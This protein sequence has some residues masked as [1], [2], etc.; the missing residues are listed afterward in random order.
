MRFT[1]L[2]PSDNLTG[3]ARVVAVYARELMALGHDVLVV[4]CKADSPGW[5]QRLRAPFAKKA[6]E[7][8]KGH[9]AVSGVPHKVMARYGAIAAGDVPDADVIIATWWETAV[10]MHAMPAAK[11]K[12]VHLIQGYEVWFGPAFL[13]KVHAAL[14]LPNIKIAIS[15]DLKETIDK[16]VPGLAISL[17]ANAVDLEQFQAPERVRNPLPQVGFIYA[18]A[19]IKGADVCAQACVL[20]RK[21]LPGLRVLAFGTDQPSAALPLPPQTQF[22][23]RP[24]QNALREHYAACDVWLFGSRLDSFG[25]PILEAMACRTPV[26]GVPVG[27]APDLIAG[28]G[29]VLVPGES[30]QAMSD[31]IIK[32]CTQPVQGWHAMSD[33]A[34]A[35]AHGYSW[36]DATRKLV[37]KITALN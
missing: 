4:T 26:I 5:R 11:G 27:A 13:P 16:A 17:V 28:G 20:A 37:E 32:L 30:P 1:F 9:I 35:T 19:A 18:L 3:G 8:P 22:F 2:L 33:S 34:Y 21:R 10:W 23:H 29:G 31:A 14:R 6:P 12:K 25:L 7:T 36:A 24:E 15:R